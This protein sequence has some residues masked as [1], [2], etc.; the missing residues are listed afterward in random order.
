MVMGNAS[1]RGASTLKRT[2]G[3]KSYKRMDLSLSQPGPN[4]ET[5]EGSTTRTKLLEHSLFADNALA[6]FMKNLKLDERRAQP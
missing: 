6:G 2:W 3:A 1:P 4:E 5:L